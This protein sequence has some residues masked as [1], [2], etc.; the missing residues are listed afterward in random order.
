MLTEAGIF[1]L[2]TLAIV[3]APY[4]LWRYSYCHRIVP[5]VLIQIL[6]GIAVGPSLLGQF[7]PDGFA[8]LFS[9]DQ[10]QHLSGIALIAIVMFSFVSGLHLDASVFRNRSGSLLLLGT[11]NV[12]VPL[13]IGFVG[14]L[15]FF[16]YQYDATAAP[17][18]ARQFALAIGLCTAVTAFPVLA[19]I[20]KEMK[21][22]YEP[23]GQ[24]ALRLA[25]LNDAALWLL[26]AVVLGSSD[27][28]NVYHLGTAGVFS[29]AAV[30]FLAMI[31]GVR[32]LLERMFAAG[33]AQHISDGA[34]I[35]LICLAILSAVISDSL[36]LHYVLGAFLA[37]AIIPPH[38]GAR[39]LEKIESLIYTLFTPF[40]FFFSGLKADIHGA[41]AG[42][43]SMLFFMVMLSLVG[44]SATTLITA[45]LLRFSWRDSL[46][47]GALMQAK[48][49]MELVVLSILLDAGLIEKQVFAA[50]LVASLVSTALAVAMA[51]SALRL[52]RSCARPLHAGRPD[53]ALDERP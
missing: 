24:T 33:Q 7:S 46:V 38:I 25:A 26:L 20:L 11:S 52:H 4:V 15:Y 42:F 49:L 28:A 2:Q 19:S 40:F 51:K 48:G 17:S 50:L 14:G 35:G 30:Y 29:A 32:P 18:A 27:H 3:A 36:G 41:Q 21:L 16:G 22:I 34:L 12:F 6:A 23:I 8:R 1:L 47:L 43:W 53:T 31:Y 39:V 37:G 44:K 5:L 45:R 10:L 9:P 13:L